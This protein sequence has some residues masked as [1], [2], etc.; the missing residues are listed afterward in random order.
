MVKSQPTGDRIDATSTSNRQADIETIVDDRVSDLSWTAAT[1]FKMAKWTKY[2]SILFDVFVV[3][4]MAAL[5]VSLLREALSAEAYISLA[6]LAAFVSFLDLF[7]GLD[8]KYYNFKT[9]AESYN[10][11]S[12]EFTEY[13]QLTLKDDS[14]TLEHKKEVLKS[15]TERHRLLNENTPETWK[16]AYKRVDSDSVAG[17]ANLTELRN[18]REHK[19]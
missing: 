3:L 8:K 16:L 12:K 9:N 2:V 4:S 18:N 5:S 7:L 13:Y 17:D 19:T 14:Y 10:S 1:L 6:V 11:L 15:L